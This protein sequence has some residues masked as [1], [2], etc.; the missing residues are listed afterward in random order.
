VGAV[1]LTHAVLPAART[2][3]PTSAPIATRQAAYSNGS[4]IRRAY[5]K[6]RS[7][8]HTNSR[9]SSPRPKRRHRAWTWS[10]TLDTGTTVSAPSVVFLFF[11]LSAQIVFP[12]DSDTQDVAP[13]SFDDSNARA[14]FGRN[15]PRLQRLKAQYDP[16]NV[17][18]KWFPSKFL[19]GP[20]AEPEICCPALEWNVP[21]PNNGKDVRPA[22]L[23]Y[24]YSCKGLNSTFLF[25]LPFSIL[26]VTYKV[27]LHQS[28][29]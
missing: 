22:V 23:A 12:I 9:I 18:F 14:L 5:S 16:E 26:R 6:L 17:F 21:S 20:Y 4:T 25:S 13:S 24:Q 3:P 15:Y 27:Y 1:P 10:P 28:R 8:R 29:R 11:L 19:R 7:V 2:P